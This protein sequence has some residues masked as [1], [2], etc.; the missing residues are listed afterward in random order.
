MTV[1]NNQSLLISASQTSLLTVVRDE[2]ISDSQIPQVRSGLFNI[3]SNIINIISNTHS[4]SHE[5]SDFFDK[6]LINDDLK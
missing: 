4:R 3:I 2:C 5:S 1:T 6:D